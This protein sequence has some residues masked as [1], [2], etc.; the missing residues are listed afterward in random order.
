MPQIESIREVGRIPSWAVLVCI[1]IFPV[2]VP[3]LTYEFFVWENGSRETNGILAGFVAFV[4]IV[5]VL[6][7]LAN[8]V[9]VL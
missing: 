2:G 4:A 7:G 1:L 6:I 8:L 9:G 3:Y 5:I